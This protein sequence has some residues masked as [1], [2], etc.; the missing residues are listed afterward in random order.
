[1]T[2]S[3]FTGSC[4]IFEVRTTSLEQTR[5]AG[6][7]LAAIMLSTSSL[8]SFIAIDGDLGAGKTEFVRGFVSIVSPGSI[9]RSPTFTLVNEYTRGNRSVFHFDAYRIKNED[10]LYSTGFYDYP[11]NGIFL[12]EWASLIPYAVPEKHIQVTI[13]KDLSEETIRIIKCK[14]TDHIN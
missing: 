4:T 12:V 3:P 9:V 2:T 14:V 7:K 11:E 13:E 10:D 5:Q 8:P 6:A 1:M